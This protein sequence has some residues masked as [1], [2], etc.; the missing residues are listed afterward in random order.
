MRHQESAPY[1]CRSNR[2]ETP[3]CYGFGMRS[4]DPSAQRDG[5]HHLRLSSRRGP[6]VDGPNT[7][8]L[9]IPGSVKYFPLTRKLC[10]RMGDP[11]YEFSYVNSSKEDVRVINQNIAVNSERFIMGAEK[12][13]LEH[14]IARSGTSQQCPVPRVVVEAV[15]TDM[16]SAVYQLSFW[17]HGRKFFYP[18]R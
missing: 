14:V 6:A 17:P 13:Q 3:R 9:G 16:D 2:V 10:L 7:I 18:A 15:E 8:G 11:D 5:F 12:A 1:R 4:G